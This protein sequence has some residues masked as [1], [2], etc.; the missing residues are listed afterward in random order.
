[1]IQVILVTKNTLPYGAVVGNDTNFLTTYD[2]IPHSFQYVPY[3]NGKHWYILETDMVEPTYR[4]GVFHIHTATVITE[5]V[6]PNYPHMLLTGEFIN[7]FISICNDKNH[8]NFMD[9]NGEFLLKEWANNVGDFTEGDYAPVRYDDEWGY[10]DTKGN[11]TFIDKAEYIDNFSCGYSLVKM[12]NMYC[13]YDKNLKIAFDELFVADAT[14]FHNGYAGIC[15]YVADFGYPHTEVLKWM[16]IN[17][18]GKY[19]DKNALSEGFENWY[20]ECFPFENGFGK[21]YIKGKGYNFVDEKGQLFSKR[22]WFGQN[23]AKYLGIA[24]RDLAN[25]N[26]NQKE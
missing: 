14:T 23:G 6:M 19:I 13:Y 5:A 21:I 25:K 9:E 1:M 15:M 18:E 22:Y 17:K 7:G 10:A 2:T 11:I 8:W 26:N 20:D 12:N 16:Y 4:K 24:L 3:K